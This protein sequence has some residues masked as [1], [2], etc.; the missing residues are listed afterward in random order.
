MKSKILVI[1]DEESI[2]FTFKNFLSE[3]GHKVLTA[4]DYEGALDAISSTD[5]DFII[6]D[7]ILGPHSGIDILRK[8][9]DRDMH[10]PV[11]I[12]TGEPN[13]DSATE[14]VRLGAFDY[15]YKPVRKETLLRVT[16]HAL[17]HKSILDGKKL[18]EVENERYRLNLEAIFKSLNDGIITVD[19]EMRVIEAN[20]ATKNICGFSPEEI[21][22]KGF[23]KILSQCNKPCYK[24]LKETLKTKKTIREFR[25]ECGHKVH[26]GQIVLLTSSP[27]MDRKKKFVGA[28]LVARDITRLSDLEKKL[29]ERHKFQ[30]IIGKSLRMQEVYR[31]T[32]YLADTETNVLV[33]GESG[34]GKELVAR[35][36]HHRGKRA[37][38]PLVTVN[39]SALAETLLESELFGHV[40]GAFTG[41]IKD[42]AG[43]FQLADGGTVFLDEIG[44]ISPIIQLKLLRVLQERQF[45]RVGDS[46]TI[47][48]DVRVIA[49]TNRNLKEK[50]RL[51]EFRE[52]LYYRLKV[53]EIAIPPLRKRR[54]D[55]PLLVN[56]FCRLFENS[57]NKKIDGVTDKVLTTFMHYPWPG[58]VRELKNAIE[59]AFVICRGRNITLDHLP[60]EIIEYS[61]GTNRT[62]EKKVINEPH[63]ILHA[64]TKTDWNKAKAARMLGISRQTI[65]RKINEFGL[66]KLAE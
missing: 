42:K 27:L 23:D 5:L 41:A 60:S 32:E 17:R 1:D 49:A 61:K 33:T 29:K 12:I 20:E 28:V 26:S 22:G 50:I 47:K 35:A 45:E 38:K 39:C 43:R 13:M 52:D 48:A 66:A 57:F 25:V 14:A 56:H 55:L 10:C 9:K 8:V 3:E 58:N 11:L 15:I 62:N 46:K 7:I 37:A 44:D 34:T 65:Y 64:L 53:V 54:E 31:L 36:I 24:V 51:G 6:T 40:K 18:L 16:S 63:E 19:R 30:N 2:R 4:E 59:H 21:V